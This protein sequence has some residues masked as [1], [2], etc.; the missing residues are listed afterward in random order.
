MFRKVFPMMMFIE[1]ESKRGLDQWVPELGYV[2]K[3]GRSLFLS[4]TQIR[5]ECVSGTPTYII[6]RS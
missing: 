4:G 3:S 6:S 1:E 5:E 2:Q